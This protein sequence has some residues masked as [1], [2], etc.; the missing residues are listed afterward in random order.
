MKAFIQHPVEGLVRFSKTDRPG[1]SGREA[2]RPVPE[3]LGKGRFLTLTC[4]QGMNLCLSRCRFSREYRARITWPAPM[5]TFVFCMAGTTRTRSACLASPVEM[6]AGKVYL[7]YFEAPVLDRSVPGE[8]DFQA[9]VVRLSG[10]ALFSL[11]DTGG[12]PA[13]LPGTM[14]RDRIFWNT[15]MDHA[16]KAILFQ[17]FACPHQGLIRSIFLESKAL[18]LVAYTLEQFLGPSPL[19]PSRPAML[20]DE[21]ERILKAREL[22]IRQLKF[23]PA[24]PELA[25]EVGMSHVRLTRG[26]KKIFGCTVFE[27]LRQ[28]RLAYARQLLAENRMSITQVA[29]E[30]GFCSSSHFASAFFK[31]FGTLPSDFREKPA[32]IG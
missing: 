19:S 7:H 31:R 18:E 6:T 5:L 29:F 21:R 25:G 11:L 23:P 28:E 14:D 22:L 24:L 1:S 9:V 17:M 15:Q 10:E 3:H 30:A 2:L 8:R 32:G 26:F 20:E 16:M 13:D 27:Y 12:A 4:R